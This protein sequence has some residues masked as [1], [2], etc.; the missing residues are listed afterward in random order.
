M[1]KVLSIAASV[2]MFAGIAF[3]AQDT[4]TGTITDI[5]ISENFS[6]KLASWTNNGAA[7]GEPQVGLARENGNLVFTTMDMTAAGITA[8]PDATGAEAYKVTPHRANAYYNTVQFWMSNNAYAAFRATAT[9]SGTLFQLAAPAANQS[10]MHV[11][12]MA[13]SYKV[14]GADKSTARPEFIVNAG[15]PAALPNGTAVTLYHDNNTTIDGDDV[16]AA[17]FTIDFMPVTIP[18]GTYSGSMSYDIISE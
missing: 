5:V 11:I 8:D 10:V 18:A 9:G 2:L 1:K 14:D 12:P 13:A 3:A 7:A 17:L 15:D 4:E 16:F 6:L